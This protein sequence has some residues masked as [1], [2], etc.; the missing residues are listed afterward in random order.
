M[1]RSGFTE[2]RFLVD[3]FCLVFIMLLIGSATYAQPVPAG[4]IE[5]SFNLRDFAGKDVV[6]KEHLHPLLFVMEEEYKDKP[7]GRL[8]RPNTLEPFLVS[9]RQ[10]MM[11][12]GADAKSLEALASEIRA[13]TKYNSHGNSMVMEVFNQGGASKSCSDIYPPKSDSSEWEEWFEERDRRIDVAMARST[14]V[15]MPIPLRLP[16]PNESLVYPE[17]KLTAGFE[18]IVENLIQKGVRVLS[19]SVG[20]YAEE[21]SLVWPSME[22]FV[23]THPEVLFVVAAGDGNRP[24]P[25]VR[26]FPQML[27]RYPNVLTVGLYEEGGVT[28]APAHI[29]ARPSGADGSAKYFMDAEKMHA[30]SPSTALLSKILAISQAILQKDSPGSIPTGS[31]IL[32][33]AR[34]FMSLRANVMDAP[35]ENS[36]SYQIMTFGCETHNALMDFYFQQKKD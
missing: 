7:E 3:R 23:R 12:K 29:L 27:W 5:W 34:K 35:K 8:L 1:Q 20:I 26:Q 14:R 28:N 33:Q 24:L 21:L 4:V 6:T 16:F 15:A 13:V 30:T 19:F 10:S 36:K 17:Q 22:Q 31:E 2:V 32:A 18:G 11:E 25:D 9:L